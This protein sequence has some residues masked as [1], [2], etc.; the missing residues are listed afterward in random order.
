MDCS[1]TARCF[2][3]WT[4]R[5]RLASDDAIA[6]LDIG[7]AYLRGEWKEAINGYWSPLYSWLLGLTRSVLNPSPSWEF[8]VVKI[9][10]FLIYLFALVGFEFFLSELLLY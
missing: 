1:Y 7:D 2:S 5:Y 6:Y 9:V 4:N 10:N 3:A 8:F